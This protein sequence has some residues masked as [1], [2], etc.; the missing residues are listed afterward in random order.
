M[1]CRRPLGWA[2]TKQPLPSSTTRSRELG[3][4]RSGRLMHGRMLRRHE[5][6]LVVDHADPPAALLAERDMV[7][8]R[9]RAILD[10]ERQSAGRAKPERMRDRRLDGAAMGYRHNIAS[11]M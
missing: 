7:E 5:P 1:R 6:R 10:G 8:P 4:L 2:V 9:H 11:R 3:D